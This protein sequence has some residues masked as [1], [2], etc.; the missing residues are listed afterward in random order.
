V[1]ITHPFHPRFGEE[2]ELLTVRHNWG[3]YRVYCEDRDGA[4]ISFPVPWTNAAAPDP[5]VLASRGRSFFRVE[6]LLELA[7]LLKGLAAGKRDRQGS[8][9]SDV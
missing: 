1:C 5:V 2:F 9:G 8:N 6:D 7:R 3:E 4:V